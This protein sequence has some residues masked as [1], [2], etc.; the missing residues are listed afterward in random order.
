VI[1]KFWPHE[2]TEPYRLLNDTTVCEDE[3]RLDATAKIWNFT[4]YHWSGQSASGQAIDSTDTLNP[5]RTVFPGNF[6]V[7]LRDSAGCER[8]FRITVSE[9][10]PTSEKP[11]FEMPNVFTPN[12]DG[13]NDYFRPIAFDRGKNFY[14]RIYNRWGRVVYEFES[15]G[16][17]PNEN[18]WRGWD[19]KNGNTDAP[20]G[21]YFWAVNYEDLFGKKYHERG[22]ITLLR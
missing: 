22:T 2:W 6:T 20:E 21:V 4:T 12:G 1:V 15:K 8:T 7:T 10:C 9:D 17:L 19:G 11:T 18:E 5:I 13:R 3:V 14:M 16:D